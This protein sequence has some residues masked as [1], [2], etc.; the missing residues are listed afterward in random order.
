[1]AKI[2]RLLTFSGV[3]LFAGWFG[4]ILTLI[5]FSYYLYLIINT[6]GIYTV[7]RWLAIRSRTKSQMGSIIVVKF[8]NQ[9]L[10]T[11][12]LAST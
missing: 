1:V 7:R 5:W 8:M 4:L 11:L 10:S 3:I 6:T 12:Y 9:M 2:Y